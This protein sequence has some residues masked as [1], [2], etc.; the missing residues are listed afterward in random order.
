[1]KK[2]VESNGAKF[3]V[4]VGGGSNDQNTE[5]D[6][7]Y[8]ATE[9]T[10]ILS[11]AKIP[12]VVLE[13]RKVFGGIPHWTKKGHAWVADKVFKF[14]GAWLK[15]NSQPLKNIG[16]E[17]PCEQVIRACEDHGFE[18]DTPG[19]E[20]RKDCLYQILAGRPPHG[21]DFKV[22]EMESCAGRSACERTVNNCRFHGYSLDAPPPLKLAEDCVMPA[23]RGVQ[24]PKVAVNKAD[25][26]ACSKEF[27]GAHTEALFAKVKKIAEAPMHK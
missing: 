22:S 15:D 11:K 8:D 17:R 18:Y 5:M 10:H 25:A 9:I 14:L 20:L 6:L 24:N 26:E 19:H 3:V 1:M 27:E 21:I 4:G 23:I 13:T 7:E 12:Y 16:S 2:F